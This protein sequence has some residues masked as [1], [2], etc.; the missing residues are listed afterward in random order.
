MRK[1]CA[2]VG[3]TLLVREAL[4]QRPRLRVTQTPAAAFAGWV[5]LPF[6]DGEP[7]QVPLTSLV[8]EVA[9]ARP[10]EPGPALDGPL[11]GLVLDEWTEVVPRRRPR[12]D[13]PGPDAPQDVQTTGLALN[14]KAARA[15]PPQAILIAMSPDGADWTSDRLVAA[16]DEAMA[17]ARMRCVTLQTLPFAG[18]QLPALYFRDWSLQGEPVIDWR[19]VITAENISQSQKFL[20]TGA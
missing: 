6:P 16:L 12:A 4:G 13:L 18:R 2:A 20:A 15:R 11:A 7:P 19:V 17:L 3:E 8:A 1:A 9:G 10:D 14:A 5:G